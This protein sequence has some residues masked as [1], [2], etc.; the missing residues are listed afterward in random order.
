MDLLTT[1]R[2]PWGESIF[3]HISWSLFWASLVGG[4]L[5][6]LAHGGFQIQ[7]EQTRDALRGIGVDA[8]FLR[9]WD[10]TTRPDVIHFFGKIHAGYLRYARQKG[11]RTVISELHT[12]LGSHPEWKKAIQTVVIGVAKRRL[13]G[14]AGRMMWDNYE[15]ADA[16]VAL[17]PYEAD[18]MCNIFH[19]PRERMHVALADNA[20]DHHLDA[21]AGVLAS[22]QPRPDDSRVV[23]HQQ[24]A[25]REQGRQVGEAE[26]AQNGRMLTRV[27]L[28]QARGG[29]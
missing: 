10:D 18:L 26:V 29:A 17:T 5:F 6:L 24:V 14:F 11:I 25:R 7:I 8:E 9:W 20:L 13:P 15:S 1:A 4:L 3:T 16:I 21:A 2:S 12:G 23:E 19:A 28:Q 22:L 27:D